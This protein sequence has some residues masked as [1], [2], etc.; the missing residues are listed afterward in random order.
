[1]N[2]KDFSQDEM[3][4]I[5]SAFQSDLQEQRKAIKNIEILEKK[6]KFEF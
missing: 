3:E 5:A 2:I 6:S 1:M 4:L